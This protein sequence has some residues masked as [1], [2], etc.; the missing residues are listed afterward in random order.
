MNDTTRT[1]AATTEGQVLVHLD[2][3]SLLT[4]D[5]VRAETRLDKA[6]VASITER[7]VITPV[8]AYRREDDGA[9]GR[10]AR[11][12][13]HRRRRA[14]RARSPSRSTSCPAPPPLTA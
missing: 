8:I 4:Q 12:P 2:P 13:P 9:A 10:A 6:F 3:A 7:G 5:N 11:P 14:G 1:T